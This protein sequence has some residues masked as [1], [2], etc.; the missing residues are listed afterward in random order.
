[1][2][3]VKFP[4]IYRGSGGTGKL[5]YEFAQSLI[6]EMEGF[7]LNLESIDNK[8]WPSFIANGKTIMFNYHDHK[9]LPN[10]Y[11]NVDI[12]LKTQ[13]TD[14]YLEDDRIMPWSQISFTDWKKF[15]KQ[16]NSIKYTAQSNII[17]NNQVPYGNAKERRT[18]VQNLLKK[19]YDSDVLTKKL[20]QDHFFNLINSSLVYVHVPGHSNNMI[21][22]AHVQM[23]AFGMCVIT[24]E[25]PVTFP[26]DKKPLPG[27]HYIKCKDD[28]SD[29]INLIEWCKD[30][31]NRC[32][33]IGN[34]A[35]VL[36]DESLSPK[37]MGIYLKKIIEK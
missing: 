21:D 22:R 14:T 8:L 24:T 20:P 19:R 4:S 1:M 3:K 27:I 35:K 25:I 32:I 37:A 31:R 17:L 26:N 6:S 34:N 23:F 9:S 18:Y 16:R 29:L 2:I 7:Q 12:C 11:K 36:F 13:Y 10:N 15:Y 5:H 28:Y 30:N 33:E